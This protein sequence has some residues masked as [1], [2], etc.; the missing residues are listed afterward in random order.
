[1]SHIDDRLT[2]F[3]L[4]MLSEAEVDQIERELAD[5]AELRR[6]LQAAE[7]LVAYLS[8]HTQGLQSHRSVRTRLLRSIHESK[9]LSGFTE[10]LQKLFD[11]DLEE[12][13]SLIAMV[14]DSIHSRWKPT[15]IPDVQVMH[16]TGGTAVEA[17][18]CGFLRLGSGAIF[19]EHSHV[20][21][22]WALV[23]QGTIEE[24]G[25]RSFTIGD[26]AFSRAGSSHTLRVTSTQEALLAIVNFDGIR[27]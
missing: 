15:G 13:E 5:D 16:F 26:L 8:N 19:P 1:M 2:P 10:R 23:V 7:E 22:E 14:S 20:G 6:Q 3:V 4:G 27:F 21:D 11:F 25:G 24:L 12:I 17:A 18:D 9:P